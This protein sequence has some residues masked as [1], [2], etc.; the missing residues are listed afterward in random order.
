MSSAGRPVKLKTTLITGM[1]MFG[2]MSVGV[3][4][5]EAVPKIRIST[6]M[7]MNV[8]GRRKASRTI[9]ITAFSHL[10]GFPSLQPPIIRAALAHHFR[11]HAQWLNASGAED[12]CPVLASDK[13][14]SRVESPIRKM[15]S[16]HPHMRNLNYELEFPVA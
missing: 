3:R 7:T 2:K 4:K 9:P 10:N 8:Y 12:E 5:A 6:T 13:L 1:L 15:H 14:E 11:L 16:F